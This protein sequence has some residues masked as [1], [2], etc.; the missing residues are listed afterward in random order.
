METEARVMG[1]WRGHLTDNIHNP[2][3]IH[4]T[5][6]AAACALCSHGRRPVRRTA[7]AAAHK[8][9]GFMIPSRNSTTCGG[10]RVC[11]CVC[12]RERKYEKG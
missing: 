5:Y 9:L 11:V 1:K 6:L 8:P 12:V 3:P 10:G 2:L 7:T 4:T